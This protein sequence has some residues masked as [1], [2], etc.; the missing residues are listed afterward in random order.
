MLRMGTLPI[1]SKSGGAG[2]C[3]QGHAV[4]M[5]QVVLAIVDDRTICSL[6]AEG[7]QLYRWYTFSCQV[8]KLATF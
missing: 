8:I 5:Y 3:A 2:S 6:N 1:I 7:R 4:E